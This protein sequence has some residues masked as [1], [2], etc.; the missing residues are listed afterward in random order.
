LQDVLGSELRQARIDV[1]WSQERQLSEFF[2]MTEDYVAIV[3]GSRFER[4]VE[5]RA[6]ENAV[7]RRLVAPEEAA[8]QS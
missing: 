8:S 1:G 2:G 7:L 3:S 4:V 5:R 6:L